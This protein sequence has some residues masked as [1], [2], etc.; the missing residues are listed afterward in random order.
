VKRFPS[1]NALK[2][3]LRAF[4]CSHETLRRSR[5]QTQ[6]SPPNDDS[7]DIACGREVEH[8]LVVA[9]CDTP[10]V[11]E[12]AEGAFDY[13]SSAVGDWVEG[14]DPLSGWIVGNDRLGSAR[15]EEV[16]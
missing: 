8:E 13:I 16:T 15:G 12:A 1:G 3:Q 10:P 11:L 14:L 4:Q 5:L 9:C 7:C 2:Q 6:S